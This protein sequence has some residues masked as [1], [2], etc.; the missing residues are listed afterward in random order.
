MLQKIYLC[1]RD[2]II[3]LYRYYCILEP[4]KPKIYHFIFSSLQPWMRFTMYCLPNCFAILQMECCFRE[5]SI[6]V[7]VLRHNWPYMPEIY[8]LIFSSLQPRMLFIKYCLPDGFAILKMECDCFRKYIVSVF[9]FFI[10]TAV[11]YLSHSLHHASYFNKKKKRNYDQQKH[12]K[13]E[14]PILKRYGVTLKDFLVEK[15]PNCVWSDTERSH[16]STQIS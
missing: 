5:C 15:Y 10:T 16:L 9:Q 14:N 12:L 4:Y 1:S 11:G 8:Y 6:C 2:I 3:L 13:V 7:P